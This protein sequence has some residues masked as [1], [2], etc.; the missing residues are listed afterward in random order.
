ME[1]GCVVVGNL[2][3]MVKSSGG[4]VGMS[5]EALGWDR[6][7]IKNREVGWYRDRESWSWSRLLWSEKDLV[8]VKPKSCEGQT[9]A[10]KVARCPPWGRSTQTERKVL[11]GINSWRDATK[12]SS[13]LKH[14]AGQGGAGTVTWWEKGEWIVSWG[15]APKP[16]PRIKH[17]SRQEGAGAVTCWE[18]GDWAPGSWTEW[19]QTRPSGIKNSGVGW[20][21]DRK[22]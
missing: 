17:D 20:Y 16:N 13:R 10:L 1:R 8:W 5:I 15:G 6:G 11:W 14:D 22:C 12:Q 21:R 3:G 19:K 7:S 2:K 18:R 9:N 4:V